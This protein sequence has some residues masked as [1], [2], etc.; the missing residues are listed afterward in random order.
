[1]GEQES[2][3]VRERLGEGLVKTYCDG[4]GSTGSGGDTADDV[5]CAAVAI[6]RFPAKSTATQAKN[7]TVSDDT[8]VVQKTGGK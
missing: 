1:M 2:E 7:E 6:G 8:F 3:R 5:T 4:C